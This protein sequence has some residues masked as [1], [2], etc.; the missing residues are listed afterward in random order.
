MLI[1]KYH[2]KCNHVKNYK[3]SSSFSFTLLESGYIPFKVQ[4]CL[5]YFWE[6][7][8]VFF[9]FRNTSLIGNFGLFQWKCSFMVRVCID[10]MPPTA[11]RKLSIGQC[12]FVF[13]QPAVQADGPTLDTAWFATAQTSARP[14]VSRLAFNSYRVEFHGDPR[15]FQLCTRT[16]IAVPQLRWHWAVLADLCRRILS[17]T[18]MK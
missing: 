12:C 9:N 16:L 4:T 1:Q 6:F 13:S 14:T 10:W 18:C 15:G 2:F 8:K 3:F 5:I 17:D 11:T 7:G